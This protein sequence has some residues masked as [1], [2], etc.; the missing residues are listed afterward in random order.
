M[1]IRKDGDA[2]HRVTSFLVAF[3]TRFFHVLA[4]IIHSIALLCEKSQRLLRLSRKSRL[5]SFL[6]TKKLRPGTILF[7]E[8]DLQ[9]TEVLRSLL[10]SSCSIYDLGSVCCAQIPCFHSY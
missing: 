3:I 6:F 7:R 1:G 8:K 4:Q 9:N 2:C 10:R 5:A